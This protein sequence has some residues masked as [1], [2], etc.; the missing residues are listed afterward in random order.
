MDQTN[1]KTRHRENP[2]KRNTGDGRVH[3]A[4]HRLNGKTAEKIEKGRIY[5][6]SGMKNHGNIGKPV[7]EQPI[8]QLGPL[9]QIMDMS[10]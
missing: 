1:S 7:C 10:V 3:V 2:P 9:P 6:I 5:H 8:G 4:T